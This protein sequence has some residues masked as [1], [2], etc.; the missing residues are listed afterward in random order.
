MKQIETLSKMIETLAKMA[1]EGRDNELTRRLSRH[2]IELRW[3][4]DNNTLSAELLAPAIAKQSL[5]SAVE[6]SAKLLAEAEK[7]Q[8]TLN[9]SK[10]PTSLAQEISATKWQEDI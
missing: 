8:L 5:Q 7:L 1:K 9:L 6:T 3:L 4:V 10:A 2:L